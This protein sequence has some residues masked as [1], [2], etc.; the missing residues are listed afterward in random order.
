MTTPYQRFLRLLG[1]QRKPIYW[2]VVYAML[3]GLISLGL[4][5]GVQAIINL[6]QGGTQSAALTLLVFVVAAALS[7]VGALRVMQ[8]YVTE[9]LQRSLFVGSAFEFAVRLPDLKLD[10]KHQKYLPEMVNY[11]FD[12]VFVQKNLPKIT[13]D[14]S[15]AALQ[16][17]FGM[18]LLSLY[19]AFF[20]FFAVVLLFFLY[21][22]FRATGPR[23]LETSIK[24]SKY[25]Y[26][27]AFWLEEL[28]RHSGLF[29]LFGADRMALRRTDQLLENWLVAR[30]KH[31]KILTGQ[32]VA[33]IVFKVAITVALL[34][35]GSWLVVGNRIN[36]GQFV[37]AELIVIVVVEATEKLILSIDKLYDLLTSLDKLGLVLDLDLDRRGGLDFSEI[38]RPGGVAFSAKNLGYRFADS[39]SDTLRGLDFDIKPGE[40]I[41]LAGGAGSGKSTLIQVLAT[42]FGDF[43]GFLA[44][45]GLP[46]G[47]LDL[48]SLRQRI[49]YISA[50]RD[51]FNGSL[52][53][54]LTLG[55]P[56]ASLTEVME[57][58][59]KTGLETFLEK[60]PDGLQTHLTATGRN[61]PSSILMKI[62]VARALLKRPSFM[63]VEESFA[64]LGP[65]DR[66]LLTALLT[67]KSA[68]WTLV[69][70]STD[71]DF[72]SRCDRVVVLKDGE[73][74]ADGPF[75]EIKMRPDLHGFFMESNLL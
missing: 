29:K 73:I 40:K 62:K 72:A 26:Q 22:V 59:R 24:E 61:I 25:K 16:I 10:R 51:V 4:P 36:I 70:I 74:T 58:C 21:A 34:L 35:V 27:T 69:G 65:A 2:I 3:A 66:A 43:E 19:S 60:L 31:F 75:S 1:Q 46:V 50:G 28:A 33:I 71:A 45:N 32:F 12:T 42:V 11:F 38:E 23:G 15:T 41:C 68:A 39:T 18:L 20:A 56:A 48:R 7:L 14:F 57:I 5:L 54:N 6:V 37:A 9:R 67:E 47:D 44:V 8:L 17:V 13:L 64:S 49:G 30:G 53:E 55:S 63:V 52:L